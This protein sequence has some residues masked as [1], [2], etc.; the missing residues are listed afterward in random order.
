MKADNGLQIKRVKP[1]RAGA[2][3]KRH[4]INGF[5][6]RKLTRYNT[7]S[8]LHSHLIIVYTIECEYYKAQLVFGDLADRED[9]GAVLIHQAKG[10][11][12]NETDE[13]LETRGYIV[14][15]ADPHEP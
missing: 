12:P 9:D 7:T 14:G 6:K 4:D 8:S 10:G 13:I 1:S 11:T 5:R 2:A 15:R 3:G